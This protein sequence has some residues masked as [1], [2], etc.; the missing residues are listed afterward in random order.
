MAFILDGH[1]PPRPTQMEILDGHSPPRPTQILETP[2]ESPKSPT[3]NLKS[4]SPYLQETASDDPFVN[5]VG[6]EA[7]SSSRHNCE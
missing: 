1:S 4:M 2:P 3:D 7:N 6:Q 5:V